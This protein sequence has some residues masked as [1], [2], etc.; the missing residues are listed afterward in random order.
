MNIYDVDISSVIRGYSQG[1]F[2]MSDDHGKLGWYSSH[3]RTLIPLD[4][5]FRYPKSLRRV[6]NQEKFSVA[7]DRNFVGVCEG[8]ADRET[9]WI[10]PELQ[11][12]YL[13]LYQAGWAHSFETWYGDQLAGGILGIAIAGI[14]VGESMFYRISEGSKVAMVKL[15]EHLRQRGYLF[16]DAQL[17]NPHLERFGSYII[18]AA[19]YQ[20]L[21]KKG[22]RRK[23]YFS[24][25]SLREHEL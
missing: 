5:R 2:L 23:C 25:K 22:L 4:N 24:D 1:Y 7:I 11:Q 17:Q 14:F 13:A 19:E 6:I 12:V 15:V 9:T 21:L 10:S 18:D 16:F 8:C 20:S 3:Q